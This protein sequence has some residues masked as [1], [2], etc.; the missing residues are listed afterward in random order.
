MKKLAVVALGGNAIT[1]NNQNGFISEQ[2]NNVKETINNLLFLIKEGYNLVLTHGNGP[3]VGNIN[4]RND[5]GEQ[6]YGIKPMP[7][8]ICVAD[9]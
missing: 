2:E 7:L 5:A 3:Q 4:M 1:R 6:L 9:S 8:D